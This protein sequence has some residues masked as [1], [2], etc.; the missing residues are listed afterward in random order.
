MRLIL[1]QSRDKGKRKIERRSE[2]K[3]CVL[4]KGG[5]SRENMKTSYEQK[6]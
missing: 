2:E 1:Q 4:K 5:G 6:K 3:G